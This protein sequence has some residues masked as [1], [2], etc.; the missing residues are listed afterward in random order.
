MT[1]IL[2]KDHLELQKRLADRGEWEKLGNLQ[3]AHSVLRTRFEAQLQR[4]DEAQ[5]RAVA[6]DDL[7]TIRHEIAEAK[8]ELRDEMKQE[9]AA[10]HTEIEKSNEA[11]HT[12]I[13][14]SNESWA[15][16]ILTGARTLNAES[17]VQRME[18]QKHLG[19]QIAM[20]VFAAAL[21]V[22]GALFVFWLTTGRP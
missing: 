20:T 19:R 5:K 7:K 9:V 4:F 3:E 13:E 14:K 11:W 15:E 1:E 22:I 12:E 18:E 16:K 6:Q 2:L 8:R 17:Q 21:S 10:M